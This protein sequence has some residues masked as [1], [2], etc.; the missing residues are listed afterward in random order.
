VM[1][2]ELQAPSIALSA[3]QA[4]ILLLLIVCSSVSMGKAFAPCRRSHDVAARAS[5]V[6]DGAPQ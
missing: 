5:V 3:A 1:S 2:P 4:K 6:V